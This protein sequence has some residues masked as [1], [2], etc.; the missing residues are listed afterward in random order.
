MAQVIKVHKSALRSRRHFWRI[1]AS[2]EVSFRALSTAMESMAKHDSAAEK[3]Y[4]LAMEKYPKTP[5]LLLS[6]GHFIEEIRSDPVRARKYILE[7]EKLQEAEETAAD[8][9]DL[10]GEGQ[11]LGSGQV[12]DRRDAVAVIN[13]VGILQI[14]NPK[15]SKM[16]GFKREELLGKNVSILM[17]PPYNQQHNSCAPH[18]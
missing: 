2:P 10:D 17:G 14:A 9:D 4:R 6:F 12:D 3:C 11:G 16:F 5:R 7:A 13:S 15:L 1:L 18:T 8:M